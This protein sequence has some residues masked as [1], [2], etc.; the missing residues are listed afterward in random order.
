MKYLLIIPAFLLI[1][2]KVSG[3]NLQLHYD[4]GTDRKYLTSTFEYFNPD[5]YGNTFLFVD[6]DYGA[7]DVKGVSSGYWEISRSF[8]FWK[9][10][11]AA[12]VEYNGGFLQWKDGEAS[13][14]VQIDDA[15][16]AGPEYNYNNADFTKG[17]T[18]QVLY[19]YIRGKHDAS[20][21]LTGVWFIHMYN[22]R[23]TFS[24]FAD[25][26]REDNLFAK[27]NLISETK[28]VFMTE[29]QVWYNFTKHFS[30]GT[31]IEVANN[32]AGIKGFQVNPTIGLKWIIE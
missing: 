21:Q 8:S 9:K 7:G 11:I 3:Q 4:L 5:K 22:K 32:F 25:F 23:F 26:W 14:I 10:P 20:F 17:L 6:M 18:L 1:M 29:P 15:W 16:L 13:G 28:F 30:V 24:G 2:F 12:H 19:K 27:N 31:E